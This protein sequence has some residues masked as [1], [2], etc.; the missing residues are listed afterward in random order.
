[1]ADAKTETEKVEREARE[2]FGAFLMGIKKLVE[3]DERERS[4]RAARMEM[5]RRMNQEV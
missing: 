3:E 1:M 4:I 2:S 5:Y